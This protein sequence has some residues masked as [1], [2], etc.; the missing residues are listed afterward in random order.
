[1]DKELNHA[2]YANEAF[3]I[4]ADVQR[5]LLLHVGEGGEKAQK[6]KAQVTV[7]ITPVAE[8]KKP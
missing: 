5:R 3:E 1:M 8:N 2:R 4:G 7:A 6:A